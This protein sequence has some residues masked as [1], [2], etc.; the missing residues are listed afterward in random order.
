MDDYCI[1]HLS[2]CKKTSSTN[3]RRITHCYVVKESNLLRH[4]YPC[5]STEEI[6][7]PYATEM[8]QRCFR[9]APEMLS[10]LEDTFPRYL[11]HCYVYEPQWNSTFIQEHLFPYLL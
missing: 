3:Q 2:Y 11:Q 5:T 10:N 4:H 8:L 1:T 7:T 9:D 6:F